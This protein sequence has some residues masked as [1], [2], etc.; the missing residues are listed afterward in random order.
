VELNIPDLPLEAQALKKSYPGIVDLIHA[1]DSCSSCGMRLAIS[2]EEYAK[3]LDWH[4]QQN[5]MKEKSGTKGSR[6]WYIHPDDWIAQS[7]K[8]ES[9][10]LDSGDLPLGQEGG[11]EN[12]ITV[13]SASQICRGLP[14]DSGRCALCGEKLE[15]CWDEDEESWYYKDATRGPNEQVYHVT[16]FQDAKE[17]KVFSPKVV[18]PSTPARN[19]SYLVAKLFSHN[20]LEKPGASLS[21]NQPHEDRT[22]NEALSK[23]EN[24]LNDT[25]QPSTNVQPET[26]TQKDTEQESQ[27]L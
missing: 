10:S 25:P 2:S 13:D 11:E 19:L 22:T 8:T 5:K 24:K 4:Y 18:T 23:T 9:P 20:I 3:H 6:N 16:C 26:S 15:H 21:G 27:T 14:G 17:M 7:T 1:G 12:V